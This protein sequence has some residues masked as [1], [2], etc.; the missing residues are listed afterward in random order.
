MTAPHQELA[1]KRTP[2]VHNAANSQP[3]PTPHQELASKRTPSVHNAAN[4]R[5]A[6]TGRLVVLASGAGSNLGAILSAVASRR[7]DAEVVAVIINRRTAG[8]G[9]IAQRAGIPV[10]CRPLTPYLACAHSEA[11]GRRRYDTEL[12]AEVAR[13]EPDLVVLAGWMHVLSSAFLDRFRNRVVNLH[14]AL[15]GQFPGPS[16]ITEAWTAY[17]AGLIDRTGAMVH[18]VPDEGV[19]NGPV[20]AS[21]EVPIQPGDTVESLRAR[22]QAA[23]HTLIVTA[24]AEALTPTPRPGTGSITHAIRA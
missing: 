22:I 15:P 21:V 18:Y 12:A 4:S 9:A 10:S 7:L 8:A 3:A 2:S 13:A 1:A 23:E 6:M 20:I 24:I 14:P 19:D 11:E 16:A 5:P 17:Q